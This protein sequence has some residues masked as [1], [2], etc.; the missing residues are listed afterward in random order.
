MGLCGIGMSAIAQ[1]LQEEGHEVFGSDIN[2]KGLRA[3]ALQQLGIEVYPEDGSLFKR[4]PD[5]LVKSSD[6]KDNNPE[7]I[8]AQSLGIKV[9]TRKEMMGEITKNYKQVIALA[10]THG[11]TTSTTLLAEF[12]TNLNLNP[13]IFAGGIMAFCNNNFKLGGK[14][15]LVLEADESDG[16]FLAIKRDLALVTN[17][18][19]DHPDFFPSFESSR[20]AFRAFCQ[21]STRV[22]IPELERQKIPDIKAFLTF[23]LDKNNDLFAQDLQKK[24]DG[25]T[26]NLSF[27][28]AIYPCKIKAFGQHNVANALGVLAVVL[29]L[30]DQDKTKIIKTFQKTLESFQGVARRFNFIPKKNRPHLTVIDDYAHHPNEIKTTIAGAKDDS[31]L[32]VLW[33]PHRFSRVKTFLSDFLDSFFQADL[34]LISDIYSGGEKPLEGISGGVL[35]EKLSKKGVKTF[36][37]PGPEE[38]FQK[39]DEITKPGDKLLFLGAG[40]SSDWAHSFA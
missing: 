26:F 36:F 22:I 29:A 24:P 27:E 13:T 25:I 8:K 2:Y 15:I 38:I 21:G 9:L 5:F 34:L 19:W 12:L 7:L 20:E 1:F 28:G 30:L 17:I 14:E 40:T 37:T 16:T 3:E 4:N 11:K 39:L 10:G 23:G 33:Q 6:I 31:R 32:I 18:N 35:A